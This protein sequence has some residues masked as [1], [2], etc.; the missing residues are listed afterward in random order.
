MSAINKF[1]KSFWLFK[2]SYW[3][4]CWYTNICEDW[5]AVSKHMIPLYLYLKNDIE[6]KLVCRRASIFLRSIRFWKLD[7]SDIQSREL[8][9][10]WKSKL[11][12]FEAYNLLNPNWTKEFKPALNGFQNLLIKGCFLTVRVHNIF[13]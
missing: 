13:S 3:W 8:G 11:K 7:R 12:L 4:N 5:V 1:S 6:P 10:F 9:D 2:K